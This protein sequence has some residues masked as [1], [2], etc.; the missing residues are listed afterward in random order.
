V[1]KKV[2][3]KPPTTFALLPTGANFLS[4]QQNQEK[5]FRDFTDLKS[6]SI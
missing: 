2:A 5:M 4:K 3:P 1:V 6:K